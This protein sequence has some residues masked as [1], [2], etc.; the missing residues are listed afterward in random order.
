MADDTHDNLFQLRVGEIKNPIIANSNA[1]AVAIFQFLATVR[2]WIFLQR[3]NGF[4]DARLNLRRKPF[5]FLACVA[6]DFNPPTHMRMF[7]SFS[8]W[9][10]DWRG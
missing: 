10:K 9:R 4:G 1:K 2:K 7:S 3:D 6:R 8:V 5:E